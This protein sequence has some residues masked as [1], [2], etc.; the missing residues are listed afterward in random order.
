MLVLNKFFFFLS[1]KTHL[2][3]RP[4]LYNTDQVLLCRFQSLKDIHGK[5][6]KDCMIYKSEFDYFQVLEG[7][8]KEK[9]EMGTKEKKK[10][11]EKKGRVKNKAVI[12]NFKN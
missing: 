9:I 8:Y 7:K 1:V 4:L 11:K 2:Y 5:K 6:V 12:F 3:C 10:K